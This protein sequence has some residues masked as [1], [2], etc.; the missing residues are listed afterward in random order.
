MSFEQVHAGMVSERLNPG[1]EFIRAD[2]NCGMPSR[3]PLPGGRGNHRA[4]KVGIAQSM[5]DRYRSGTSSV[6]PSA[7]EV[8]KRREGIQ[9]L[10]VASSHPDYGT[11][12]R[13]L[14]RWPFHQL[15]S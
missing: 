4:T 2:Q 11:A 15:S 9:K 3:Q 13:L 6:Q 12:A 8:V 5:Y 1:A 10:L 7:S 14:A